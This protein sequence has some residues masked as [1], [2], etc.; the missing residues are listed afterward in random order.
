[1]NLANTVLR[2]GVPV[3]YT[4]PVK[5]SYAA[6]GDY[7]PAAQTTA[8][9]QATITPVTGR[10]LKDMPEGV[11]DEAIYRMWTVSDVFLNGVVNH[12][13]HDYR[14]IHIMTRNIGGFN[15]CI[16]GEIA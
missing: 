7:I 1:M 13:G 6:N 9:I 4:A 14:I 10:D 3:L 5:G 2:W 16:L 8:T 11:R 15:R 12:D